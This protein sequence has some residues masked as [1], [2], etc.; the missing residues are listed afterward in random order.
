[1]YPGRIERCG[2]IH[3][4]AG[5]RAAGDTGICGKLIFGTLGSDRKGQN[6]TRSKITLSHPNTSK[7]LIFD[8]NP[9]KHLELQ[10]H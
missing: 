1:M 4:V 2:I 6:C 10:F 8:P 3:H 7:G 5:T 9:S